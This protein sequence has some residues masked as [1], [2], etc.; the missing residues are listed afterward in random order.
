[1]P[2]QFPDETG[3]DAGS[4]SAKELQA[5]LDRIEND[6]LLYRPDNLRQRAQAADQLEAAA[7]ALGDDRCNALEESIFRRAENAK[8]ALDAIDAALFGAIRGDIRAGRGAERLQPWIDTAMACGNGAGYDHLD[9]LLAGVLDL[10]DPGEPFLP[11][12]PE[13]VFYQPT[14]ARH[15]FDL[16]VRLRLSERDVLI[17]L[18]A[19]LGHVSLLAAICSAARSI[20]I[21]RE[22]AY[23][24]S[25][26]RCAQS[27]RLSRAAILCQDVR[28]ADLSTGTVFYLYTP[29]TGAILHQVLLALA[30][31]GAARPIRVCT[32]GPCTA[33]VAAQAWLR[34]EGEPDPRRVNVFHS[35]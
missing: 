14:P 9:Q 20:G 32:L 11:L 2:S 15:I 27:L 12:A 1:M 33:E 25:A 19:G 31:E 10:E 3:A 29:F 26:Q 24:A 30:R 13:M 21:E 8:R 6:R 22:A 7:A 34:G 4:P 35:R 16:L 18:G 28:D 17:D 23:V 5:L